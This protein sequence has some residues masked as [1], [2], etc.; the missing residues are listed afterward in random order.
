[1]RFMQEAPS[2]E[3]VNAGVQFIDANGDG[4]TDLLVTTAATSGY[5]PLNFGG[6]WDRKSFQRYR[7]APS[8]NLKDP[9]VKLVDLDGDGVTDAMRS[10][11]RLECFFNDPHRGWH[12]TREVERK[13]LEAFPDVSFADPRVRWADMNG[14]GLQDIVLVHDGNVEYW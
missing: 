8:F 5:F 13:A 2:L 6:Q 4:R 1:P 3:L 7:Q 10:G 9:E 11:S 14:D 12:E